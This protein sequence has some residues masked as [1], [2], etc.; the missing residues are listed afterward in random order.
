MEFLAQ[1]MNREI[2]TIGSKTSEL[3]ITRLVLDAKNA[4]EKMREQIQNAE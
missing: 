2:N 4:L 1:E 3:A